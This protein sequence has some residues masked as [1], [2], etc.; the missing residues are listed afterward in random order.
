MIWEGIYL[1]ATAGNFDEIVGIAD[2]LGVGLELQMFA[3]PG[4]YNE[5]TEADM[6]RYAAGLRGF[7]GPLTF[8]APYIDLSVISPDSYIRD[9]SMKLFVFALDTALKLGAEILVVH[10]GYNPLIAF[11]KYREEFAVD[12][13]DAIAPFIKQAAQNGLTI[14]VENIFES[15][16]DIVLGIV[17][18]AASPNVKV[19]FD[20]GH[21]NIFTSIDIHEWGEILGEHIG[22]VHLHDNDGVY[23]DHLPPGEGNIDIES[24]LSGL[25]RPENKPGIGIE[26]TAQAQ[27][28]E[29]IVSYLRRFE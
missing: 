19:C 7:A 12:F 27:R 24:V 20:V 23:D 29:R 28:L 15:T 2:A 17:E 26:V 10:S 25:A 8:H 13:V 3:L 22:Y 18:K 6:K 16:P 14:C 9:Y 11:K 5:R 1:R 21:A 4:S